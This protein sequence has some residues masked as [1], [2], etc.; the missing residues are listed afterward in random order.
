MAFYKLA[1]AEH[2]MLVLVHY[3]MGL[4]H[5]KFVWLVRYMLASSSRV[6]CILASLVDCIQLA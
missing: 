2:M 5:R 6:P 1:L 4:E 3:T